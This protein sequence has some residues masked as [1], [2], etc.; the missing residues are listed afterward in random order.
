MITERARGVLPRDGLYSTYNGIFFIRGGAGWHLGC[1]KIRQFCF[2]P[3]E[4]Q[5]LNVK[6]VLPNA[7]SG[8]Q[9]KSAS[10]FSIWRVL[11]FAAIDLMVSFGEAK[12]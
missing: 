3:E 7:A 11:I 12:R 6:G 5:M 10:V 4:L 9:G 1:W 8:K 2:S